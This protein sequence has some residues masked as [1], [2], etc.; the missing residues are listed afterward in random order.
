MGPAYP[1]REG[2]FGGRQSRANQR[3]ERTGIMP[4]NHAIRYLTGMQASR[5]VQ[6]ATE[7]GSRSAQHID[8]VQVSAGV[9]DLYK[10]IAHIFMKRLGGLSGLTVYKKEFNKN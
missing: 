5:G 4:S 9:P 3:L 8:D 7:H 2:D 1:A 6:K 10:V